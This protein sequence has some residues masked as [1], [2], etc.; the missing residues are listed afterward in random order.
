MNFP[1][2]AP[3]PAL[4]MGAV[5]AIF[6]ALST[7]DIRNLSIFNISNSRFVTSNE[8]LTPEEMMRIHPVVYLHGTPS[9]IEP[10]KKDF[11]YGTRFTV[12][13][14]TNGQAITEV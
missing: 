8:M 6:P 7:N 14:S 5:T 4:A 13:E 10:L 2:D 12:V 1:L 3:V 11:P 9:A